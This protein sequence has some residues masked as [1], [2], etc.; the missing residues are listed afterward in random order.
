MADVATQSGGIE[1]DES[2]I[3]KN[4]LMLKSTIVR[5]IMTPRTVVYTADQSTD[6]DSFLEDSMKK[7]FSRIPVYGDNHDHISGFVLKSELMAAKFNG[8]DE[9]KTLADFSRPIKAISSAGTIYEAFKA[10]T[11]EKQHLMLVVDEFGGMA[12]VISMEDVVETLLG[13]EIVD[14]ADRNEDMQVL[15]RNLWAQR[16]KSMGI[17][18][19]STEEKS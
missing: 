18:P 6:L 9:G 11:Q 16:A 10:M 15:A 17:D 5:D 4:L 3:L 19:S 12:G 8:Q 1:D 2:Q 14:E 7:P 13:M